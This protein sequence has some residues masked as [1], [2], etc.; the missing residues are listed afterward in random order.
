VSRYNAEYVL[1][2]CHLFVIL[3]TLLKR[4]AYDPGRVLS[5]YRYFSKN[6]DELI[7]FT[8]VVSKSG[9]WIVQKL[10]WGQDPFF[11]S[12]CRN[13]GFG[14]VSVRVQSL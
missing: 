1:I 6:H 11:L 5:S 14:S 8:G 13:I 12:W 7:N 9:L 4:S 10:S 3:L 2:S